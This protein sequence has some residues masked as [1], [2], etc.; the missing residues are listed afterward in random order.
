MDKYSD[1]YFLAQF[2]AGISLKSVQD[3]IFLD[4][5]IDTQKA[6]LLADIAE[7]IWLEDFHVKQ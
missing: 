1:E 2:N 6:R 3:L 4:S 7:T 5:S